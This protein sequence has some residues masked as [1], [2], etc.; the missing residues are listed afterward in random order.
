[1]SRARCSEE[2]AYRE[3]I[4]AYQAPLQRLC[5]GYE[6]DVARREEL[7]QEILLA[8]WRAL[9]S[10][11]GDASERTF[12]FR[13]AHNVAAT[14]VRQAT[15]TPREGAQL[16]DEIEAPGADADE[17]LDA[18]ARIEKLLEAIRH[19]PTLDRQIMMLYLEEL[20]QQEIALVMGLSQ[21]NVSTRLLR[22]RKRLKSRVIGVGS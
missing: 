3:L 22:A 8:L 16:S 19:L 13:V 20:P 4:E 5:G 21:S 18:R 14:H 10:F 15:R 1:M 9:P 17:T 7:Y 12:I 6:H 2:Q 11:R